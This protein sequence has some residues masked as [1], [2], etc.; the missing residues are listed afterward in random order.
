VAGDTRVGVSGDRYNRK[1]DITSTKVPDSFF[2]G[3]FT[4]S[5]RGD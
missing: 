4:G 5:S 1:I 2:Q 3:S